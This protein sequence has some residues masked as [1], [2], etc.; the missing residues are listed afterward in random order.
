MIGTFIFAKTALYYASQIF[1]M[2]IKKLCVSPTSICSSL[3]FWGSRG[4]ANG[5]YLVDIIVTPFFKTAVI[6]GL[7]DVVCSWGSLGLSKFPLD[8]VSVITVLIFKV[9]NGI[10]PTELTQ[11]RISIFLLLLGYSTCN[12]GLQ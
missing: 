6:I 5:N 7:M 11:F 2:H 1:L 12:T 8:T 4:Y 10:D 9:I 3:N